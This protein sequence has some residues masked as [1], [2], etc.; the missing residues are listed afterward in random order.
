MGHMRCLEVTLP[1]EHGAEDLN[2]QLQKESSSC[3]HP[4]RGATAEAHSKKMGT[5][6]A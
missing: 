5:K 2:D 1:W 4:L 6:R 3:E